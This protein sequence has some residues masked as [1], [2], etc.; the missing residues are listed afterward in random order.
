MFCAAL[1]TCRCVHACFCVS[2]I[3]FGGLVEGTV[4][5]Y[6]VV[7]NDDSDHHPHAKQEC[8]FAA[9]TTRVFPKSTKR[10]RSRE[11]EKKQIM[12]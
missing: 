2:Y 5:M 3:Y 1:I 7:Q 4:G 6:M 11:L 9:E 8:V 10:E 12:K